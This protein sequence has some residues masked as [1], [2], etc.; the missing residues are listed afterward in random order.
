MLEVNPAAVGRAG[1]HSVFTRLAPGRQPPCRYGLYADFRP[2]S[3]AFARL[4]DVVVVLS[5]E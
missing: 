1:S 2:K 3:L 4:D 5:D